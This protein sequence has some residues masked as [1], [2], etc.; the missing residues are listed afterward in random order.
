MSTILVTGGAGFIGSHTCKALAQAGFIPITYDDLS[1]GFSWSVKWGPLIKGCLENQALFEK[2]CLEKKPIAIMH[3]AA[4]TDVRQSHRSPLL[5]YQKNINNTFL[6]L[7]TVKRLQIPHVIFSSTCAVYGNPVH[8]PIEEDHPRKPIN[9][10]GKTKLI[11]E[12]MVELLASKTS[13]R[14][15]ILRYFNAAG[16]DPDG[17]L[18]ESHAPATHLIPILINTALK[19]QATFTLFGNQHQTADGTPIR[20]YIHVSDLAEAHVL[21]LR[22]L[23]EKRQNLKLNLGS[24]QGH[25]IQEILTTFQSQF[26]CQ[27]PI[28]IGPKNPADPP[29]LVAKND[30]AQKILNW[31]PR[32]SSLATILKTTWRWQTR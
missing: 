29:Q 15:A 21:S 25:S 7:E 6:L 17:H 22:H 11:G 13:I 1:T 30:R 2:I 14:I 32:Y 19:K 31:T 3:F 27:L 4:L 8:M 23:I 5:Y 9:V 24:G 12:K 20:D 28:A 18:G 26:S 10:Y 16:A